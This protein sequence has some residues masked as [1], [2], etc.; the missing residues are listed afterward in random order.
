MDQELDPGTHRFRLQQ[1]DLDGSTSLSGVETVDVGLDEAVRL[2]TPAP[3]PTTGT[4]TLEFGVKT[5][6]EVT[7]SVYNVLGQRVQTLY[8]GTPQ[9]DQVRDVTVDASSLPSGVY[10]VRMK[11]DGQTAT[12]RLTVVR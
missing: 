10:F 9:A 7:V 2:S 8:Q 12:Q 6:T 5:S 3:N 1:K 4:A 11:A